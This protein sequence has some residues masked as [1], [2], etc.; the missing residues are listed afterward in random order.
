PIAQSKK[1][2]YSRDR[3]LCHIPHEGADLE[4]PAN[5]PKDELWV[6]SV[7][8]SKAPSKPAYVQIDFKSGVPTAIDG[9]RMP[10]HELI[11]RLNTLGGAHAVG[12]VDLVENRLVG[13][14]SRGAYETPGGTILYE[15]HRALESI[16]LDRMTMAYKQQAALKYAEMVYNGQWFCPLREAMD[17][18]V[19]LQGAGDGG[20]RHQPQQPLFQ[21]AGQFHHGRRVHAHG[22]HR[23]HPSVRPADAR[24]RKVTNIPTCNTWPGRSSCSPSEPAS[25]VS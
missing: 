13:I 2:I 22:R 7:P 10:G 14:K 9:V 19:A 12:Q 4:D 25:A 23:V 15:A 20:V 5:E 16:T 11:A 18:F 1:K 24:A 17:A 21:P 6:M 8:A 3:N